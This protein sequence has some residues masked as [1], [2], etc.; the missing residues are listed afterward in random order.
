MPAPFFPRRVG[1]CTQPRS[2]LCCLYSVIHNRLHKSKGEP[3]QVVTFT[4][5]REY[6]MPEN[7]P[8]RRLVDFVHLVCK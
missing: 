4:P 8:K 2:S 7:C 1:S 3:L 5:E 6:S